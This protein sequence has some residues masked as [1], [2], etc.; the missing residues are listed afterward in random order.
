LV[1]IILKY[2]SPPWVSKC[3]EISLITCLL[4]LAAVIGVIP[5]VGDTLTVLLQMSV[6]IIMLTSHLFSFVVDHM[7]YIETLGV[8]K[9]WRSITQK[10]PERFI[11]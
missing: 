6:T 7:K 2:L 5:A 4:S 11:K 1:L 8:S 9:T 10:L 3:L